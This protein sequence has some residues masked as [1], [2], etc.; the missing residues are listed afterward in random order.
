M[1]GFRLDELLFWSF[2]TFIY[3]VVG[4]CLGGPYSYLTDAG[5]SLSA[6]FVVFSPFVAVVLFLL[7][8]Y[9][10]TMMLAR[11]LRAGKYLMKYNYPFWIPVFLIALPVI[12]SAAF[13]VLFL[14]G[15]EKIAMTVYALRFSV[16]VI[17]LSLA[18]L[19]FVMYCLAVLISP[20]IVHCCNLADRLVRRGQRSIDFWVDVLIAALIRRR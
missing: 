10:R 8:M 9:G 20:L 17:I 18:V 1:N 5:A 13:S 14:T 19:S 6:D 2:I 3:F 16:V 7:W 4:I 11:Y 12:F 15:C